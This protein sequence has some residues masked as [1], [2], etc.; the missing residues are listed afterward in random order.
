MLQLAEGHVE[1]N[2]PFGRRQDYR[3]LI[4]GCRLAAAAVVFAL[5]AAIAVCVVTLHLGIRPVLTG[6]MRPDYGPGGVLLT[7]QVPTSSLQPG[8]VVLFAPPG[9][10][11]E[12]A[13]RLT[14]VSPSR[15]GLVVTT[16]GD[17]NKSADPWHAVLA[18]PHVD[19]V[20]GSAPGVGRILVAVHGTGQILI[21]L[22]GG[23]LA[24]W[25]VSGA[26]VSATRTHRRLAMARGAP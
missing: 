15:A 8:M 19:R 14:S 26:L 13:H 12:Y 18:A 6:S 7:R 5:S 10:H 24:V 9:E 11:V 22:F 21:V 17:A 20:I 25:A 4:L 1:E 16:K 23:V 2:S 3:R